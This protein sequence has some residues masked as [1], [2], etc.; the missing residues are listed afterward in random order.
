M[1][2]N[3]SEPTH[4]SLLEDGSLVLSIDPAA[5][6]AVEH[7]IP[8]GARPV[9]VPAEG[10]IRVH[11]G[12]GTTVAVPAEPPTFDFGGIRCWSDPRTGQSVIL[13]EDRTLQGVIDLHQDAADLW[14]AAG[15][16]ERLIRVRVEC[17]LNIA[18]GLLFGRRGRVLVHA[19]GF[20]APDGSAWLLAGDT[21]S[22]KS[23]TCVTLIGA[24]WDFLADDQ[25]VLGAHHGA[26]QVE[27]IGW[28]RP[29]SLDDGY[30]AG[31]SL[32]RRSP[33]DAARLGPGRWRR[34][35]ALGGV[36]F[37]VVEP[38]AATRLERLSAAD[39]LGRLIRHAPW[40]PVD[41]IGARRVLDLLSRV[42]SHPTY[43]LRLGSDTYA[44]SESLIAI[45]APALR[46]PR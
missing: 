35:A 42:A 45:L 17:A 43:R 39:A 32:K 21:F 38:D 12:R 41:G 46:L 18:A 37:P 23:S 29:F 7:W 25:V 10:C 11:S 2:A 13:T 4:H 5:R 40:L 1:D 28:A 15:E 26:E 9:P 36:L 20:L 14:V 24:G 19:A 31:T 16:E 6:P 44:T 8:G 27:V 34:S 3:P 30:A 22:G 33:V